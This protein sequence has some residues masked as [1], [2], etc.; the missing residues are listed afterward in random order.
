MG[1]LF[2]EDP[3]AQTVPASC[4]QGPVNY[5]TITDWAAFEQSRFGLTSY[6]FMHY[7][8]FS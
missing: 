8:S 7:L 2:G 6:F 3:A 5:T 4:V 1:D